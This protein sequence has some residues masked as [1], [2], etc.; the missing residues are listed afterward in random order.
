VLKNF[1]LTPDIQYIK[2]PAD[3]PQDNDSWILGLRA[4]LF[5]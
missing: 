1:S 4:M 5:L 3:N 2:D